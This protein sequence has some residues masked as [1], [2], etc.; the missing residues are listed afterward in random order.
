M[1]GEG[2]EGRSESNARGRDDRKER[3]KGIK[4]GRKKGRK[5]IKEGDKEGRK[6]GYLWKQPRFIVSNW[7]IPHGVRARI[8]T[9]SKKY[10]IEP[11]VHR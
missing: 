8:D 3:R 7:K 2:G 6:E 11:F 10:C 1:K 9:A 4:E 5:V